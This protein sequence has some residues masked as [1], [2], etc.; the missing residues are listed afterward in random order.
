MNFNE[1]ADREML[2]LAVADRIASDLKSH[3][4][5][6]ETASIALAGGTTPGPIF[7]DLCAVDLDW[8]NITV[9]A[10]DERWVPTDHE[11]SNAKLISERLLVNKASA[12]QFLPFYREGL[13]P[14]DAAAEV[15]KTIHAHRPLTVVLL[16]MG[17]DM[18][19]ASLFPGSPELSGALAGNAPELA[20]MR[21]DSQPEVRISLTAPVLN[22]AM[23]KHLVIFGASKREA[24]ERAQTLP[25]DEAP[26]NAVLQEAEVHW[27]P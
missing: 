21:P 2:V 19:T 8:G 12:A 17:E 6:N 10:S 13:S 5:H 15:G 18:H 9:M 25:P 20:V 1:Y 27:A 7:D 14:E 4:L 16:G 11:R 26:I 24:L 3:L 23:A 22:G